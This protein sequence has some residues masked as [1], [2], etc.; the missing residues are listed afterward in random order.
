VKAVSVIIIA[1]LSLTTI[2]TSKTVV[3]QSDTSST[4]LNEVVVTGQYKPQSVKQSV[5]QVRVISKDQIQRQA[6]TSVKDVLNTQLNIRFS[7]DLATGGADISMMGLSGQNVKILIDGVPVTGRQGT[8]NEININQLDVNSI[9]RIEIIEGPMSV[10]YGADALAG[11]I[12]IITKKNNPKQ[13]GINARI[14]EETVGKEYGLHQGI[15]NQYL[16]AS[17][18]YKHW[19]ING[20]VGRNLFNGWKDTA[21]GRELI[22]HKKDQ[23]IGNA[24]IGYR[25][26]K[27]HIYY[28][29]DGLDEIITN[30]ANPKGTEPAIDQDYITDR[31]MQQLQGVYT[32]N[33]H[34]TLNALAS[35]THFTRQVYSTL[36]YPNGDV[37]VAT[38]AGLHS[39]TT[40]DGYVARA[41]AVYKPSSLIAVQPGVDINIETGEG[42]RIKQGTQRID[43]YAFFA[44][45]DITPHSF[46]QVRPGVRFEKNSV[47]Q[48]P[49]AIPSL[50][51][52]LA[53]SSSIDIRLAYA[54]GFRAPSLR[55]LY[56]DFFDASHQIQGNPNLEAERSNSFT[57]S[58][59]WKKKLDNAAIL[60]F[61]MSG[62]YNNVNNLISYA[63]KADDATITSFINISKYKTR[64]GA[65]N[66][67]F[68]YKKFI[69]SLGLAYTGRYNEY[70]AEEKSLPDFQWSPEVNSFVS[71]S[72]T[73]IGLDV[74]LFYKLTGKL[75]YYQSVTANNQTTYSLV[76]TSAYHWADLTLNKKLGAL[77]R[78]NAGVRNL[79]NIST[80]NNTAIVSGAHSDAGAK[81]IGYGRAFFV[82]LLFNWQTKN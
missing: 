25:T 60:S 64:G 74:N 16:G 34:W 53:V 29:L 28:R 12:N 13:F 7:Q 17:A 21:I 31:L 46:I 9:E 72:F 1:I 36:Y 49:P 50:N 5:Y 44:T 69:G 47:Y 18:S 66:G 42:E 67:N 80:V 79:F 52:K 59:N 35:Y 23:I 40:F 8:S 75:P 26:D 58:V 77:L 32:L 4:T 30:P 63:A 45:A 73:K 70:S 20:A 55:E 38:A 33:N 56:Y 37:R 82:G 68:S 11:V 71:Y 15:H 41:T 10:I 61:A 14:H 3:A 57:G 39:L 51:I 54:K 22:W 78:L 6:A 76:Q 43:D 19:Y 24:I 27:L 81:W 2:I 48:A 62:F 65:L